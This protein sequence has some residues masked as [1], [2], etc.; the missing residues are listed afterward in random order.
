[1]ICYEMQLLHCHIP[2]CMYNTVKYTRK[3][4][5]DHNNMFTEKNIVNLVVC[6][7]FTFQ[8]LIGEIVFIE[9]GL[10][11]TVVRNIEQEWIRYANIFY[12]SCFESQILYETMLSYLLH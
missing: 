3:A 1:M 4:I 12:C 5:A 8:S 11:R 2:L 10:R 7:H 6:S 9:L